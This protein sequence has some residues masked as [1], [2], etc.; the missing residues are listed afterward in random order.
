MCIYCKLS[1]SGVCKPR[2]HW[3]SSRLVSAGIPKWPLNVNNNSSQLDQSESSTTT[4]ETNY[5]AEYPPMPDNIGNQDNGIDEILN[6]STL[7]NQ[8]YTTTGSFKTVSK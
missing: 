1:H 4:T 5:T 3:K 6:K 7:T 2:T 8:S